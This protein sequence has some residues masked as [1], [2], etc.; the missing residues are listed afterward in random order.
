MNNFVVIEGVLVP[1]IR[2]GGGGSM[3]TPHFNAWRFYDDDAGEAASTALAAEDINHTINAD[4]NVAFQFR[5]R[6]DET[7]GADGTTMHDYQV[8]YAKNGGIATDLTTTDSGDGI[9]AVAAGLT[10]DNATTDRSSEPIS[11]PGSGSF[12]AGEQSDDGLV[13][14]MQL[15]AN[16][17]TEHAYGI[18]IVSANVADT[19]YFEF[20]FSSPGGIVNNVTPRM[21]VSKTPPTGH[22]RAMRHH[23]MMMGLK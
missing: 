4:S 20:S 16:N 18:E 10:N 11:N 2:G 5:A 21:T 23:M 17:F 14:N 8:Q 15:T 13:D 6:I 1:R 7:G 3:F 19:D 12:V 9:R 22:P